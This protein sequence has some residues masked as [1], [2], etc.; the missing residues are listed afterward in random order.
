MHRTSAVFTSYPPEARP[1]DAPGD[2]EVARRGEDVRVFFQ[3]AVQVIYISFQMSVMMQLHSLFV[4]VRF[5]GIICI[6]QRRIFKWIMF[7]Q[8]NSSFKYIIYKE[9]MSS[10]TIRFICLFLCLSAPD[11][12][13]V[14]GRYAVAVRFPPA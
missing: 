1:V 6:R 12:V 7:V 2:Q 10:H 9:R 11:K 5:Q 4:Y 3:D 8:G 13:S 14:R